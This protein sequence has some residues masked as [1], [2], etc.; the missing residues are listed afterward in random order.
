MDVELIQGE[1]ALKITVPPISSHCL[2]PIS[3]SSGLHSPCLR[4]ITMNIA[5]DT[6]DRSPS[7]RKSRR[8]RKTQDFIVILVHLN[9]LARFVARSGGGCPYRSRLPFLP[10]LETGSLFSN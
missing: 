6:E 3:S 1:A 7:Q 2:E 8:E 10:S 9:T 4:D 5:K